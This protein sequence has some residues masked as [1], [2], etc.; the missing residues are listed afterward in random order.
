MKLEVMFTQ[1]AIA[2]I[3]ATLSYF[4]AVN[5]NKKDLRL[6]KEQ[7]EIELKK[8]KL[9]AQ[10]ELEKM[11]RQKELEVK[12]FRINKDQSVLQSMFDK[13]SISKI[14]LFINSLDRNIGIPTEEFVVLNEFISS[15]R[16][17]QYLLHNEHIELLKQEFLSHLNRMIGYG[18]FQSE[19]KITTISS[20][21]RNS[22]DF[23]SRLR[24]LMYSWEAF[25]KIIRTKLPE[26]DLLV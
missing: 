4:I 12:E 9:E 20:S 23:K 13:Y 6:L 11:N 1:L 25:I 17:P 7:S 16:Q 14:N 10:L 22:I 19:E 2:I 15:I 18:Q 5:T 8:I 24:D 26:F 3:P 21:E